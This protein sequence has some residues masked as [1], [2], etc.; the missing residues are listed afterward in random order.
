MYLAR[1][2][3]LFLTCVSAGTA[4]WPQI[5]VSNGTAYNNTAC[6][7][8]ATCCQSSFSSSNWGCCPYADA[9]CCPNNNACC[10]SGTRCVPWYDPH[11][12]ITG[13]YDQVYNCTPIQGGPATMN[14]AVCKM[15][16]PLE[17]STALKNV[18]IIGDSVSIM[19]TEPYLIDALADVALVQHAPWGGDGGAEETAYALQ[20]RQRLSDVIPVRAGAAALLVLS[21][22]WSSAPPACSALNTSRHRRRGCHSSQTSSCSTAG[23]T[24]APFG[25]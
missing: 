23:C 17:F 10:P 9:V 12:N 5:C 22:P 21:G 4:L 1:L 20:V 7:D 3:L 2:S 11:P 8:S 18:L 15:G 14:K 13:D 25:T 24:R 19:Y 6:P 16:P